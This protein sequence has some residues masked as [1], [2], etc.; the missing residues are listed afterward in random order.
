[1]T[2]NVMCR[3]T[4]SFYVTSFVHLLMLHNNAQLLTMV[5]THLYISLVL[6][7]FCT[8]ALLLT[9]SLCKHIFQSIQSFFCTLFFSDWKKINE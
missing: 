5:K 7:I 4:K 2:A 9:I 6:T 3:E 8:K 1:M